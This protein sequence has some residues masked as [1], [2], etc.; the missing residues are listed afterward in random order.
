MGG[1]SLQGKIEGGIYTLPGLLR[2]GASGPSVA[3]LCHNVRRAFDPTASLRARTCEKT[4]DII[5]RCRHLFEDTISERK[6]NSPFSTQFTTYQ[7]WG[8]RGAHL[9][10]PLI[11]RLP[12]Y[13]AKTHTLRIVGALHGTKIST[14]LDSL[15]ETGTVVATSG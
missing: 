9:G 10:A 2:W 12:T 11:H 1:A 8:V 15:V 6:V 13:S 14:D 3:L 7:H 5:V 4:L